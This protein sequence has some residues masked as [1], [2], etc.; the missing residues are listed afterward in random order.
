MTF[1]KKTASS[2]FSAMTKN[3]FFLNGWF[4]K[5]FSMYSYLNMLKSC[6]YDEKLKLCNFQ[7][8]LSAEP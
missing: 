3:W 2:R 6:F 4:V 1:I 5:G 7:P 8:F